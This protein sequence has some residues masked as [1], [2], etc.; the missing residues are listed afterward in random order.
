MKNLKS[1]DLMLTFVAPFYAV[2]FSA[3]FRNLKTKMLLIRRKHSFLS[4]ALENTQLESGPPL[5]Y[6]NNKRHGKN[7]SSVSGHAGLIAEHFVKKHG[8]LSASGYRA[9]VGCFHTRMPPAYRRTRPCPKVFQCFVHLLQ[10]KFTA[11]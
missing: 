11:C 9:S 1:F 2:V 4:H 6:L 3:M 10:M 7:L 5:Q 8:P